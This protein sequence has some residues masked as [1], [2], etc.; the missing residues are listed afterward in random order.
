MR[1]YLICPVRNADADT[2]AMVEGYVRDLEVKGHMVHFPPRDVD[3]DDE[4][5][6]TLCSHHLSA[7]KLA[8]EVHAFWDVTS[9][10]SHFDLGMA[11]ALSKK[12]VIAHLFQPDR[13]GKSYVKVMQDMD[14]R[15]YAPHPEAVAFCRPHH[16]QMSMEISLSVKEGVNVCVNV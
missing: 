8:D 3:Q 15:D 13:E 4:T 11:Y 7:M 5:G 10:G 2:L 6:C 16:R 9:T 1:I 14:G 12:M